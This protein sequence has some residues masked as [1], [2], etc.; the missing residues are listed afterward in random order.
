M[1]GFPAAGVLLALALATLL[2]LETVQVM[3]L[4]INVTAKAINNAA[5]EFRLSLKP[6]LSGG[7]KLELLED[8]PENGAPAVPLDPA[9]WWF[10]SVS[11]APP[12]LLFRIYGDWGDVRMYS[13]TV[14]S[15]IIYTMGPSAENLDDPG[16][17]S[18]GMVGK[19]YDG[20]PVRFTKSTAFKAI[21]VH[22][23]ALDSPVIASGLIALRLNPP[24]FDWIQGTFN[25]S[26]PPPSDPSCSAL[27][28]AKNR[29]FT[30]NR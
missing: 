27:R 17:T 2:P 15:R 19:V 9:P 20:R 11:V 25:G 18:V 12:H 7:V 23:T 24:T 13:G 26:V 8:D 30:L 16:L 4:S 5:R 6:V 21:A 28:H 10:D 1:P 3:D 14:E 29:T 22:L